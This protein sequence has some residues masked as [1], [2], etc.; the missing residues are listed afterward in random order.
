MS[1]KAK[2]APRLSWMA[3]GVSDR[4][5]RRAGALHEAGHALVALSAGVQVDDVLL[6]DAVLV[7]GRGPGN[8]VTL[9]KPPEWFQDG[10]L[11]ED[12]SWPPLATLD[13]EQRVYIFKRIAVAVAGELVERRLQE[14]SRGY[15]MPPEEH[16]RD[17]VG[18]ASAWARYLAEGDVRRAQSI[19]DQA[20]Q[21]ANAVLEE[22]WALVERV[23][24]ALLARGHLTG[25]ELLAL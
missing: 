1:R 4:A 3:Q 5:L 7:P 13:E 16:A 12:Q 25:P 6:N 15:A 17:D 22:H 14:K 11:H 8:G 19:M 24:Q 23:A 2:K 9:Y 20:T 18:Q 21:R 10:F